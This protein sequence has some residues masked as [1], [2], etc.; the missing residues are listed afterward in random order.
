MENLY[1]ECDFPNFAD[2]ANACKAKKDF[3]HAEK[4]SINKIISLM[5]FLSCTEF[6]SS[7]RLKV[8]FY[9]FVFA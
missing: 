6:L 8:S 1:F 2:L 4:I 5:L 7:V 3:E 9:K